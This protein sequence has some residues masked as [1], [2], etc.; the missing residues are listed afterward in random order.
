MRRLHFAILFSLF[1][2]VAFA[3]MGG[4]AL[5][6]LYDA[7]R[8]LM[9]MV[10][11]Y[12]VSIVFSFFFGILIIHNRKAYEYVFPV[13][14]VLQAIPILGFFP[15][16]ILFFVNTFPG[17]F[18]GQEL[19]AIF[20]IFTSMTWA[21]VFAV[22]E[23]GASITNEIRDL[24]KILNLKGM[25]YLTQVVL[26]ISF[27]QFVSGSIAGWGG[28]WYFLVAAE[29]L[30]LGD[31][32]IALPGLG[33]FISQS[34]F[35]YN[36]AYSLMGIAMLAFLVFGINIYLWQPLLRRARA[37][38][39][40]PLS[41]EEQETD[42]KGETTFLVNILAA[43]YG[44]LRA[45]LEGM[46]K[47]TE[48]IFASL[49]VSPSNSTSHEKIS[50]SVQYAL[51]G[52]VF[53]LFLYFLFF[54]MPHLL[55]DFTILSYIGHSVLRILVAF[56]I[57]L[58]WTAAVAVFLARNKKAMAMV[59]P[60][61]DLGQ[62]IPAVSIFP[63]MV[64]LVVETIGKSFGLALGL[65]VASVLLVLTGMQWY[66]LFNLIRAAQNIPDDIMDVSRLLSLK[67]VDRLRNI[68]VPAIMPAVFVG[69]LEAMGGGWNAS[70]VSE[71]IA[72]PDG[73]PFEMPGIGFLLSQS[74]AAGNL[75]GVILAVCTI[76]LLILI[77]HQLF[78][79]P[80]VRESYRY[81]F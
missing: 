18:F 80:M 33:A 7:F 4:D 36:I 39:S 48:G 72:S 57:A 51:T 54:R 21:V 65:E 45:F 31:Q 70:I 67:T 14:D 81:K 75:D 16:A 61:F 10:A 50:N 63:V 23:S 34:A 5:N 22:V 76:T 62:S 56:G 71:Y 1:V 77:P 46:H 17:G 58:L 64:V 43:G 49:S 25:R 29:Y 42:E 55:Q 74:S 53:V 66:L 79:K 3:V 28:G 12:A 24:A 52:A 6:L 40:K 32:K 73:K 13:L 8:S 19:S 35:S 9:R 69:G 59:M 20:L 78:W 26:P 38:S 60:F 27:P 68:M 41:D 11:A 37:Y 44:K 2:I 30:A 47:S 15:F